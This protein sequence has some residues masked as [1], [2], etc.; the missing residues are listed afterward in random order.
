MP[1]LLYVHQTIAI[2]VAKY[3][4]IPSIGT[5]I[6]SKLVRTS[7]NKQYPKTDALRGYVRVDDRWETP[8]DGGE[9]PGWLEGSAGGDMR[10]RIICKETEPTSARP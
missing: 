4:N 6:P 10:D 5:A 8:D 9:G 1:E 3:P 2:L 7:G